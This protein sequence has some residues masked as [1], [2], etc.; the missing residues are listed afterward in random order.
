MVLLEVAKCGRMV[1][2]DSMFGSFTKNWSVGQLCSLLFNG[3]MLAVRGYSFP[4][5]INSPV[6]VVK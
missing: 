1:L 2:A 3:E 4:R 5:Q 6:L